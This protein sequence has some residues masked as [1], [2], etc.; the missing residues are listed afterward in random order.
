MKKG[1][2]IPAFFLGVELRKSRAKSGSV[3]ASLHR[4]PDNASHG[5]Q[6]D[7]EMLRSHATAS[8]AFYI[9][10]ANGHALTSFFPNGIRTMFDLLG[11]DR[12]SGL[13][14]CVKLEDENDN[15]IWPPA[16]GLELSGGAIDAESQQVPCW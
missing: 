14:G 5:R 8:V 10:D 7:A 11:Q 6:V 3:L 12:N 13:M 16:A 9:H 1:R 15:W 2:V 4:C